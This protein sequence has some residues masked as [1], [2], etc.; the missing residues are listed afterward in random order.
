MLS[1]FL[2]VALAGAVC[3][4]LKILLPKGEKSRLFAP[5]RF[6]ASLVMILALLMPVAKFAR[7]S[8]ASFDRFLDE[9]RTSG[10]TYASDLATSGARA[11]KE[12]L[13][14]QFPSADYTVNI[15]ADKNACAITKITVGGIDGDQI[16]AYMKDHYGLIGEAEK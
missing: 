13:K 4:L 2:T 5:F 12:D 6:L 11:I 3:T 1:W 9:F 16:I 7:L 14:T 8:D 10:K 15:Y